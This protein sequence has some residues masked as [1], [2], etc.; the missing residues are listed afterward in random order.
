MSSSFQL[1]ASKKLILQV[2]KSFDSQTSKIR[3]LTELTE[4]VI[5]EGY[6]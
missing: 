1:T 5:S 4:Q 6:D 3:I 2:L